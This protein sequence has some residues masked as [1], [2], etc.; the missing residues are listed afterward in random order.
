M[1]FV[2]RA[3]IT[4]PLVVLLGFVAGALSNSGD[5]NAWYATLAK[6][7]IQPPSW[8]FP[9]AWTFFYVLMGLALAIVLNARGSKWRGVAVALFVVQF[10]INLSWSPVF[11]GMH[12]TVAGLVIILAMLV[13]ATLTTIV[14]ARVRSFAAWL[15]VPYLLWLCFASLLN[16][17]TIRLNPGADHL[18][19]DGSGTQ[20]DMRH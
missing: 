6:P 2:R 15:M 4:V 12:K 14:F 3:L 10:V 5:S 16:W 11:F 19:V 18:V 17:E 7:D 9:V 8:A 13:V 20:I 1:A